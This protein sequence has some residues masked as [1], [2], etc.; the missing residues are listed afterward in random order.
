MLEGHTVVLSLSQFLPTSA[1]MFSG[2]FFTL[3]FQVRKVLK[4]FLSCLKRVHLIEIL[5]IQES[6]NGIDFKYHNIQT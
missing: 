4:Q 5:S 6:R 1:L 3:F 2:F